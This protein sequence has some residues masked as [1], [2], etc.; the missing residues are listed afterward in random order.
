MQHGEVY[1]ALMLSCH[2]SRYPKKIC[3]PEYKECP[4]NPFAFKSCSSIE[5]VCKLFRSSFIGICMFCAQC[6]ASCCESLRC[7][8][9]SCGQY[10]AFASTSCHV[11]CQLVL[12]PGVVSGNHCSNIR[13]AIAVSNDTFAVLKKITAESGE[14]G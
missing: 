3:F 9:M 7:A 2:L 8:A 10:L 12:V 1:V 4:I 13:Y 11:P 6:N 5:W 14:R